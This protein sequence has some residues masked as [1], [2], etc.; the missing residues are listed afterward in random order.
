MYSIEKRIRR[1]IKMGPLE[2]IYFVRSKNLSPGRVHS[3]NTEYTPLT[4]EIRNAVV[5]GN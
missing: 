1:I 5:R 3:V 2:L 4:K